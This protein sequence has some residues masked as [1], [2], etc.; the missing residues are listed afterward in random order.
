MLYINDLPNCTEFFTS[1][2]ADDTGFVKSSHDLDQLFLSANSE[3]V[4]ASK[5]FQ[6]NKLTLNVSKT[7]YLV[8]RSTSMLFDGKM[9]TLKIGDENI[10]RIGSDCKEK[11]FKFV[12]VRL[13]E[14]LKWNNQVEHVCNKVSSAIF[15]L[16]SIKHILPLNIRKVVYDSLVKSHLEYGILAWGASKNNR[17]GKL[18][19]L[20]KKAIRVLSDKGYAVHTDPLFFKLGIL[21]ISDSLKLHSS[22]FMYKYMNDK[23]PLSFTGMF[24]HLAAPNRTKSVRLEFV[25]SKTLECFPNVFMPRT[26]NNVPIDIK[27]L[28]SLSSFKSNIKVNFLS[29]YSQFVCNDPKC[30]S[31]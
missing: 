22:L 2:F 12:G 19:Q 8:F 10:E 3:L 15:A 24:Q 29:V 30:Y 28:P 17:I 9:Y 7:K 26:W 31:C 14:F 20:Q 25:K 21:K 27:S 6:A 13:D 11:Y 1:L 16:N 4:K 5:W 18:Y 23:L